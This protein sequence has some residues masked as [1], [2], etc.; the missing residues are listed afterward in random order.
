MKIVKFTNKFFS[1]YIKKIREKYINYKYR[2]LTVISHI[3]TVNM[4][5]LYSKNLDK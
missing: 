4:R 5:H 1:V 2:I 3:L